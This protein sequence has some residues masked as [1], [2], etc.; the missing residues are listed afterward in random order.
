MCITLLF[1]DSL[2]ILVIGRKACEQES[3]W[4]NLRLN[5][6]HVRLNLKHVRLNLRLN[7]KHVNPKSL[8]KQAG[9]IKTGSSE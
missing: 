5:R 8:G 4:L 1:G 7:L 6:K 3:H 2:L 9:E